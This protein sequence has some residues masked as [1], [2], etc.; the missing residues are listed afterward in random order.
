MAE[1]KVLIFFASIGTGHKMAALAVEEDLKKRGFFVITKDILDFTGGHIRSIMKNSQAGIN[2]VT[3]SFYDFFW[4]RNRSALFKKRFGKIAL[5]F[6]KDLEQYLI[7]EKP[8]IIISTHSFPAT[9]VA[10][11]KTRGDLRL[12][13]VN[14]GIGTDLR[15]H[16]WWPILGMDHYVTSTNEARNDLI[17][18]GV[19]DFKIKVFGIPLRREFSQYSKLK[20]AQKVH[21]FPVVLFLAGSEDPG[22]YVKNE[23]LLKRI[24]RK[25]NDKSG[26]LLFVVCGLNKELKKELENHIEKNNLDNMKAYGF[27]K[28]MAELMAGCDLL[29]TKPGGLICAESLAMGLPMI[30]TGLNFGQEKANFK[31]LKEKGAV[32]GLKENDDVYQKISELINNKEALKAMSARAREISKPRATEDIVNFIQGLI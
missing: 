13:E 3:G 1:K 20:N 21:D 15:S 6:F 23:K 16:S 31:Y 2:R 14:I 26:Y 18:D 32:I 24:L 27:V 4:Q 30:L 17:N 28:D 7:K 22:L 10:F 29:I 9:L 11:L 19:S 25:F 5:N 8:D 12:E